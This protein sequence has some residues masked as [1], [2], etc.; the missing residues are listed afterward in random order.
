MKKTCEHCGVEYEPAYNK[1]RQKYCSKECG[2]TA[3]R[4]AHPGCVAR[5]SKAQRGKHP[6]R[7]RAAVRRYA[8]KHPD[9]A[10]ERSAQ[11]YERNKDEVNRRAREWAKRN[12]EKQRASVQAWRDTHPDYG[13]RY[14]QAHKAEYAA[15]SAARR[16]RIADATV[17]DVSAIRE[18]YRRAREEEA[19]RCHLCGG[20][21]PIGQRHVDHIVPLSRGGQH[22]VR[23]LEIACAECNLR[24]HTKTPA[25]FRAALAMTR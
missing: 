15:W 20:L 22:S 3:W 5:W 10:R 4:E 21:I 19:V 24:K 13:H 9:E 25:E 7:T 11:Y 2:I 12:P 17:G 16:A 6:E 1:P 8:A 14:M 23:N 18:I